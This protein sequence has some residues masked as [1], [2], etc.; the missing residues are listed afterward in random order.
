MANL[1]GS[2]YFQKGHQMSR[3]I[4]RPKSIFRTIPQE[5]LKFILESGREALPEIFGKLIEEA[6][7]GNIKAIEFYL[8]L[9]TPNNRQLQLLP[10]DD[11]SERI[12]LRVEQI[13]NMTTQELLELSATYIEENEVL[14]E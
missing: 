12:S 7:N 13:R 9:M 3:S 6:K 5:S 10:D 4:G 14:S 8:Q 1:T 2:G 11:M